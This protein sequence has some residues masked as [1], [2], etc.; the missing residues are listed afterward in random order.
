MT[1]EELNKWN[2]RFCPKCRGHIQISFRQKK[3][4]GIETKPWSK[5]DGLSFA[6]ASTRFCGRREFV[7]SNIRGRFGVLILISC[8]NAKTQTV[9]LP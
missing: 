4:S 9:S 5:Y 6:G 2:L 1:D 7:M 3:E 8:A